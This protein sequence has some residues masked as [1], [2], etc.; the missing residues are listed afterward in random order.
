M[1]EKQSD[2]PV[3]AIS[4]I[5]AFAIFPC[6]LFGA[7]AFL[8]VLFKGGNWFLENVYPTTSFILVCAT[9]IILIP[10]LP[11]ALFKKT[12]PIGAMGFVV[13][14]YTLGLI[15]WLWSLIVAKVFAGTFWLIVGILLAG[16]GVI[17]IALIAAA[18]E[19]EWSLIVG[20]VVPGVIAFILRTIG[21]ILLPNDK[22]GDSST[23]S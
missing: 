16:F 19:G 13:S 1:T 8:L 17:P 10:S 12:R 23:N 14:Y 3:Q 15:V 21:F 18:L 20:I 4:A 6:L 9:L 11:L 2:A 5:L 7:I 22:V